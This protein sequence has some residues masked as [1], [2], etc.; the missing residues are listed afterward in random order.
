MAEET[1]GPLHVP[2]AAER[3][4]PLGQRV[5]ALAEDEARSF[6]HNYIGTEHL[7][8]GVLRADDPVAANV[9]RGMGIDLTIVRKALERIVGRGPMPVVGAVG[10]TPRASAVLALAASEAWRVGQQ[11]VA[12]EDADDN[13]SSRQHIVGPEHMLLGLAR[14]GEGLAAGILRT[15]GAT[16]EKVRAQI[17]VAIANTERP[18]AATAA[19]SSVVTCRIA[20]NDLDAIDALIEAGIRSTRSDAAAWLIHAGIDANKALFDTVYSTVA[21]IR[22]LRLVAQTLVREGAGHAEATSSDEEERGNQPTA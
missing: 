16:L 14:E 12:T 15:F 4:S 18:V 20:D 8:L 13:I 11:S 2:F 7:L 9:L 17:Y 19:K 5:L 10:L 22:R 21:E 6:D 1:P 3:L